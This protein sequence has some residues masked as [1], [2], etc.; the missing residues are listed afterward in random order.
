MA[1]PEFDFLSRTHRAI[2]LD[3]N[4]WDRARG[5][6]SR[7]APAPEEPDAASRLRRSTVGKRRGHPRYLD[8]L[9]P[10]RSP[11]GLAR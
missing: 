8:A 7:Q 4:A 1:R 9:L 2:G 10:P 6:G 5:G 11:T 3:E